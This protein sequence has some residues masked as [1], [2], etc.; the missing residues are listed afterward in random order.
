MEENKIEKHFLTV[1]FFLPPHVLQ[2]ISKSSQ[3]ATLIAAKLN[4]QSSEY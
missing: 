4:R 2:A 3:K 1:A